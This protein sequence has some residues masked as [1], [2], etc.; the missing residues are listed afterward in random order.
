MPRRSAFTLVELLVVITIIGILIALLLPAVQAA[1]EAARRAQCTNH[2]KQFGLAFH[3]HHAALGFFPTGGGPSWAYHMTYRDGQP[4]VAPDQH[5]GWGFQV[6]PYIEQE[7]VWLGG[8]KTTD[9]ERSI[10]AISTPISVFFC[11]SRRKPEVVVAAE[12]GYN[13]SSGQ[14]YGHAKNDYAAGSLDTSTTFADGKNVSVPDGVGPVIYNNPDD[15]N[16]RLTCSISQVR[17]GTSNTLL[18]SEKCCNLAYLGRMFANDNEGYTCGWNHDIMRH[19]NWEPRP[20]YNDG[21][22]NN[23]DGFGSSHPGGLNVGLCDGS[24]R[25]VQYSVDL[26]MWK[27]LGHRQDARP[28]ELP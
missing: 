28:L 10:L 5:G 16:H 17:D 4:A 23:Y 14:T 6:L 18:L 7:A 1:R 19:T 3:N 9:I 27:R 12:W 11:P 24:V 8:D 25:F 20:D 22:S 13:P 21:T 2:L 26:E 15:P